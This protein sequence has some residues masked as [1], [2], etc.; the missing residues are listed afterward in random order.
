MCVISVISVISND[1]I[2]NIQFYTTF[3]WLTVIKMRKYSITKRKYF[4]CKKREFVRWKN[5]NFTEKIKIFLRCKDTKEQV[6]GHHKT[7]NGFCQFSYFIFSCSFEIVQSVE[8]RRTQS[9]SLPYI[10]WPAGSR[11]NKF[12]RFCKVFLS[13]QE[14]S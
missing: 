4:Q 12:K 8:C 7:N 5:V 1:C 3:K 10:T 9:F 11:L 6:N 14:Q 2:R 13:R